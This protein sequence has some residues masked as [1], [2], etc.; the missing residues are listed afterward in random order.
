MNAIVKNRRLIAG[1]KTWNEDLDRERQR[2]L[3]E[4]HIAP[5]DEGADGP[6]A[7]SRATHVVE[8]EGKSRG[9]ANAGE[10]ITA[11]KLVCECHLDYL[12]VRDFIDSQE[13][14]DGTWFRRRYL[15][16]YRAACVTAGYGERVVGGA[17]TDES[18][19]VTDARHDLAQIALAVSMLQWAALETCAGHDLPLGPGRLK[20]LRGGLEV[21]RNYRGAK[22]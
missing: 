21:V 4:V 20:F 3:A 17:A 13:W 11:T 2:A 7:T 18:V 22:Q 15:L 10:R 16:G 8:I 1:L 14:A 5:R 9:S 19:R 12:H 6:A